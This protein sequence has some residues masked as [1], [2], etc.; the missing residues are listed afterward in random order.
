MVYPHH[1]DK[2]CFPHGGSF[3]PDGYTTEEQK[4]VD[5]T[6][7]IIEDPSIQITATV[8]RIPVV[9]GHSEAVNIEFENEF[10]LDDVNRLLINFPGFLVYDKPEENNIPCPFLPIT[11]MRF[12]L[13][14]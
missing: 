2:N 3:Q 10:E 11:V 6:R 9:G 7:K 13:A 1:I 4:L 8:V 12:L 5:E 14:E